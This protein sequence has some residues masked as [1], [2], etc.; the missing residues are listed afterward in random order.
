MKR[1]SVR[2]AQ[3]RTICFKFVNFLIFRLYIGTNTIFMRRR[4]DQDPQQA[5]SAGA[6]CS[7][8]YE[9]VT[10]NIEVKE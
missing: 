10:V 2:V 5:T 1:F 7:G 8:I 4:L 6:M 3:N 9:T